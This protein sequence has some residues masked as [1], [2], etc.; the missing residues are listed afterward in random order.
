M[1]A[2]RR[3]RIEA[4]IIQV[5]ALIDGYYDAMLVFAQNGATTQYTID[6]GQSRQTVERA[7]PTD[8]LK[9]IQGLEAARAMLEGQLTGGA[10]VRVI[11]D[12]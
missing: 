4:R 8:L 12:W 7:S 11:P 2:A 1:D 3:A 10:T 9:V 5:D 6:T